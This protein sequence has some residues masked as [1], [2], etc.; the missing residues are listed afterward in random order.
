MRHHFFCRGQRR[1]LQSEWGPLIDLNG[2]RMF[3]GCPSLS[4]DLASPEVCHGK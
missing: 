3:R 4:I 1:D 2:W